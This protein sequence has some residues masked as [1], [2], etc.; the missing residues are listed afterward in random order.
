MINF[1]V[2]ML[3]RFLLSLRYRIHISGTEAVASKGKTGIVFLPNHPALIDPVIVIAHLYKK[4]T[5]RPFGDQDQINRPVIG[6]FARRIGMRT[7][8]SMAIYGPASR[9]KIE[10][11]LAQSIEGLN[12]GEN[13]LLWPSGHLYRSCKENLGARSSV[14]Y[15][16]KHCPDVRVVLIRTKGLWGSSFGWG[17]GR[18][19]KVAR[20]LRKG[21][22]SLLANGIFF[23]P[24]RDVTV[25]LYEPDDLP[26]TADRI[27]LNSF[28]EAYYNT[29]P[30]R[31]TYVPYTVW[32]KS[33]RITLPEPVLAQSPDT[34][35]LV[36]A[37]TRQIV[38]N[39]LSE[40]SG[41]SELKDTDRLADDLGMDSL[42]GADLVT[43]VEQE[44]GFGQT[45]IDAIQTVGDVMQ[46]AAGNFIYTGKVE[47]KPV[48]PAWFADT[49]DN[50]L[51]IPQG[52]SITEVF[53]KQAKKSP[54]KIII[55]D[56][57]SGVKSYRDI[58]TACLVLKGSIKN[59]AGDCVGIMLPASVAADTVYLAALFAGKTPVM[60][61]WTGGI[62]NITESLDL[63]GV[64]HILT[65]EVVVERITSQGIDLSGLGNRFVFIE[66]VVAGISR[67][68]RL[69]ALLAGYI[70]WRPL[71][72][73]KV[74]PTAAVLFTSGSETRPKAV[75]LTHANIL[76]NIRDLLSVVTFRENDRM[77]G[78]LPPFHSFGLTGTILATL[79]AGL[80]T[81][82]HSNPVEAAVIGHLIEAYRATMLLGTPTFLNGIVRASMKKQ[83]ASLRL[84]VTGAEKCSEDIYASLKNLCTDTIILEGYGVTEC[85]PVISVNDENNPRPLTIGKILP[86][87]EYLLV[88]PQTNKPLTTPAT[89]ILLVRGPNVFDGYLGYEGKSPFIEVEGKRWYHTGDL[90][91]VDEEGLLTFCGRLKRFVKLGG[92]MISLPAVEA[93]LE[94]H[95]PP[96]IEEG[97]KVA[98]EATDDEYRPE[99]VLF[100]TI[101]IDRE[102]ANQHIR[103]AGL[104]A[105]HN[106][107]R[108]ISL[109]K[110]PLLGT[111]KIDYR[112]LKEKL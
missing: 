76:V 26:R 4:F 61:N 18:E 29:D 110:I 98:I 43:W 86:S 105:L 95:Y 42:D 99:L 88:E 48:S 96:D 11:A 69:C 59:L 72:N 112:R 80:R 7:I 83:L 74:S 34:E 32:E 46:A 27:T 13:L 24:R 68:K 52:A 16:L 108:V 28:L 93:V 101:Q 70:N 109:R 90:V 66:T 49:G 67:F 47:L 39:Y 21:F 63:A 30:P 58:V 111:G 91:S 77:I 100:A 54:A 50:R 85:S 107:R 51:A 37:A 56:Q 87:L 89:G 19:P 36:P 62:R 5:S 14:E 2:L 41:I 102:T 53:L 23:A 1:L 3:A 9:Q 78:I 84:V 22:F 15:I 6:W 17:P 79:C 40:L 10:K 31:N 25:E 71:Y 104:S 44:F 103:K 12:R 45:K 64:K 57:T 33:S 75:P 60:V 81:V 94:K 38:L 82:Y 65:S 92:E 8:P 35:S 97:P 55:A 20:A 73:A 106:I